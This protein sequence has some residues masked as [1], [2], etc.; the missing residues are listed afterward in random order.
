MF[1]N[2]IAMNP[3]DRVAQLLEH[4]TSIQM[5]Q[6][7]IALWEEKFSA[8]LVWFMLRQASLYRN[9]IPLSKEH[10]QLRDIIR[11]KLNVERI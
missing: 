9:I 6:V 11:R 4:W 10:R 8:S 1:Q 2:V 7:Q 3:P 5:S